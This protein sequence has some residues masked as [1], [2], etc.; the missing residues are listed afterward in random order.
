MSMS[1]RTLTPRPEAGTRATI[2]AIPNG[3][4][5][6]ED[7]AGDDD[8]SF[9][10]PTNMPPPSSRPRTLSRAPLPALEK[11]KPIYTRWN[12]DMIRMMLELYCE[13]RNRDEFGSEKKVDMR[14]V[15][16]DIAARLSEEFTRTTFDYKKVR[17]KMEDLLKI[18]KVFLAIDGV[19][20]TSY[21]HDTGFILT[22]D[23]LWDYFVDKYAALAK[24]IKQHRL[25]F[26]QLHE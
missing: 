17:R 25:K 4:A 7:S 9:P 10:S 23:E 18:W 21:D 1:L 15:Y 3:C 11:K 14:R 5:L 2:K 12:N 24:Q 19:S 6:D 26:R 13:A 22:S 20:G 16:R 8:E